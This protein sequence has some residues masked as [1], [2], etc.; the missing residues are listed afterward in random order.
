M[1]LI[2]GCFSAHCDKNQLTQTKYECG[3]VCPIE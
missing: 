3:G 2:S 1:L